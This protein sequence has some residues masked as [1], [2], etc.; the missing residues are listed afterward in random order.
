MLPVP[1]PEWVFM[2][3]GKRTQLR[4]IPSTVI[5]LRCHFYVAQLEKT[6]NVDYQL[7]N[8]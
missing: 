1:T 8:L 3:A 7:V 4:F 6:G 2:Q 5:N